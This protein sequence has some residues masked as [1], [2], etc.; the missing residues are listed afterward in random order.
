MDA[1]TKPATFSLA[2]D[3]LSLRPQRVPPSQRPEMFTKQHFL[4][5]HSPTS[6]ADQ[7][8]LVQYFIKS[9]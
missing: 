5:S 8:H 6:V 3:S 2:C 4:I 7:W 1:D 9:S